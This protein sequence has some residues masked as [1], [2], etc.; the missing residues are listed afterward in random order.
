MTEAERPNIPQTL[1]K[2][3]VAPERVKLAVTQD[4]VALICDCM[5]VWVWDC[6][7]KSRLN[8]CMWL[9]EKREALLKCGLQ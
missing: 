1:R 9:G 2:T 3:R 8:V 5:C 4:V 7:G 6:H